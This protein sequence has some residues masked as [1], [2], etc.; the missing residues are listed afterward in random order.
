MVTE[1]KY[2]AFL[3]LFTRPPR[4]KKLAG[5]SGQLE[6]VQSIAP[7]QDPTPVKNDDDGYAEDAS[8]PEIDAD[9]QEYDDHVVQKHVQKALDLMALQKVV[10]A[11][12]QLRDGRSLIPKVFIVF[13]N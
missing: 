1:L 7:T 6:A 2:Q 13:N 8:S 3:S 12:E 5:G 10:P 11:S 4:R 9:K